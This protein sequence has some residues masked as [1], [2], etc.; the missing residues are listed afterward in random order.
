MRD[1]HVVAYCLNFDFKNRAVREHG[2]VKLYLMAIPIIVT[3]LIAEAPKTFQCLHIIL[4]AHMQTLVNNTSL[5]DSRSAVVLAH[6]R[7]FFR[8]C[9]EDL[10]QD[11]LQDVRF[12]AVE[13]AWV[14]KEL[15]CSLGINI[16]FNFRAPA[17]TVLDNL[18][19]LQPA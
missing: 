17:N 1:G 4:P 10:L 8:P 16:L 11:R 3:P 9:G 13:G 6:R 2:L 14:L 19:T 18:L 12:E 5:L 7:P 15:A